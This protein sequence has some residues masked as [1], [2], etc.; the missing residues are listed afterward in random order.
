MPPLA[1]LFVQAGGL[2]GAGNTRAPLLIFGGGLWIIVI[3]AAL[4]VNTL[5]GGL[6]MVW[7]AF[8]A[9]TPVMA[10]LMAR[11]FRATVR[12][13]EYQPQPAV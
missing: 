6:V 13:F 2:R 12:E 8:V 1:I 7:A 9:L 5:G 3:V 10:W 11:R 4:L